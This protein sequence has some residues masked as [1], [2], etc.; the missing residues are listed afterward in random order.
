MNRRLFCA[1]CSKPLFH[2]DVADFDGRVC[3]P[4]SARNLVLAACLVLHHQVLYSATLLDDLSR[5]FGFR[6]VRTVDEFFVVVVH[7]EHFVESDFAA[8]LAFQLLDPDGLTRRDAV[9]LTSTADNGV[10]TAS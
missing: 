5:H 1:P 8:Y 9:L 4:V 2:L 6:G 7:G 10:H 3:L